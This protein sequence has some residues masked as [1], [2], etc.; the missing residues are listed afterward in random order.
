[1]IASSV[2]ATVR[3]SLQVFKSS[4][5]GSN[6][7]LPSISAI[8]LT[9]ATGHSNSVDQDNINARLAQVIQKNQ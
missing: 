8:I 2:Q 4:I 9:Q 1:M 7:K 5:V 3:S 6:L